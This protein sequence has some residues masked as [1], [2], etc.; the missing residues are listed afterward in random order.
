MHDIYSRDPDP[1]DGMLRP[2]SPPDNE[3]LRQAVYTR[4][5]RVLHRRRRVRQFAYAAGLMV[6]FAAGLLA[7][8]MTMP[9]RSASKDLPSSAPLAATPE[10]PSAEENPCLRRGLADDSVL[11]TE[12]TAFDSTEHRGELYR[13]AGDRYMEEENDPQSA[14]RFTATLST[15]GRSKIWRFRATITGYSWRSRTP[16]RRRKI[17]R[18]KVGKTLALALAAGRRWFC[19]GT[20]TTESRPSTARSAAKAKAGKIEAG[21]DAGRGAA[22][23]CRHPRRRRQAGRGRSRA[24]SHPRAGDATGRHAPSCHTVAKSNGGLRAE[25]IRSVQRPAKPPSYR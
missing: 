11:A 14:L 3:A 13:K 22:E 7:M 2:P 9:A 19:L 12:W 24:D 23:Q 18:S 6:S 10:K 16:D 1:L 17:M 8:W 5:R 20:V 25:K 4:T 15:T 21:G